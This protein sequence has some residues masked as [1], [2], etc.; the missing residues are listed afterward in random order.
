MSKLTLP[1]IY[2]I[3]D[4][5]LS[6]LSHAE[7]VRELASAGS[8]FVQIREKFASPLAFYT[9][10]LEAKKAAD[11]LGV[12][13]VINDRVDI[14][15]AAGIDSVH[16]GQDD[17]PPTAARKLL[18]DNAVI[19]YSTHSV[20]QAIEAAVLPIDYI[21]IGPIFTTNTKENPDPVVG[22]EGLSRVR[23]AIGDLPLVAIGGITLDRLSDV[24]SAGA[25]SVAIIGGIHN[26][27]NIAVNYRE[28]HAKAVN[29]KHS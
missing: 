11:E 17:L 24:F 18:G 12:T 28:L 7:Q 3:T 1:K 10:L 25:D 23:K 26:A 4:S 16:L 27:G 13:L 22:L 21:A 2:P 5:R 9:Q 29:V 15:I 6:T 14:A 20:E 19:G 8:R